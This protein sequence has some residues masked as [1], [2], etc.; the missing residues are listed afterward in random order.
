MSVST[1][2]E[3]ITELSPVYC[4]LVVQM[5]LTPIDDISL[6][7]FAAIPGPPLYPPLP[8]FKGNVD[9]H[10]HQQDSGNGDGNDDGHA[11]GY[12]GWKWN[13]RLFVIEIQWLP[14]MDQ[15]IWCECE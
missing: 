8:N 12:L 1:Y 13:R 4:C 9:Q 2:P 14:P 15:Y 6:V 5:Y 3:F 7:G 11:W 10:D